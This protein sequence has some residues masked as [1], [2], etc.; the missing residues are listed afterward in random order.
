MLHNSNIQGSADV[1]T[2]RVGAFMLATLIVGG[3]PNVNAQSIS[4]DKVK[5]N[6]TDDGLS[7]A[8]M[9]FAK[10]E[11][12]HAKH[13]SGGIGKVRLPPPT[14]CTCIVLIRTYTPLKTSSLC[15]LA[16]KRLLCAGG[17]LPPRVQGGR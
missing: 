12:M 16:H 7:I 15:L 5:F 1:H 4:L 17:P 10:L 13:M 9:F 2:C 11:T 14:Q 3:E 6:A 8:G